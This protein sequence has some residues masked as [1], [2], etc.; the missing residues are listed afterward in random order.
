MGLQTLLTCSRHPSCLG[1]SRNSA[2][3]T[4]YTPV[5][6]IA[7]ITEAWSPATPLC[8][9]ACP[10]LAALRGVREI[11]TTVPRMT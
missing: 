4:V 2:F 3:G 6:S 9:K 10:L 5:M 7:D 8:L 1:A 11:R